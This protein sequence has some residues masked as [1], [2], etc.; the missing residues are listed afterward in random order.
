[1]LRLFR[2][3]FVLI[4]ALTF[5]LLGVK[6]LGSRQPL[7]SDPLWSELFSDPDGSP[8]SHPCMLGV[9]PGVTQFAAAIDLLNSHPFIKNITAN[10]PI[11]QETNDG[12]NFRIDLNNFGYLSLAADDD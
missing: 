11:V 1:M 10:Y 5:T 7:P 8:C 2:I 12:H 6:W 4:T 9:Q 3:T